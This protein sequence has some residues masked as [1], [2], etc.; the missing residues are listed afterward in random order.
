[1]ELYRDW[2][3]D[4]GIRAFEIGTDYIIV[5]FKT[6]R[7]RFYKYTYSSSGTNDVERMKQLASAGDGLNEFIGT[8]KDYANKW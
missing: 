7:N 1:M 2:D 3:N 8:R 6:G 4:S 5:E